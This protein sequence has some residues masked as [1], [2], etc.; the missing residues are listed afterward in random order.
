MNN[1]IRY[2]TNSSILFQRLLYS[3]EKVLNIPV[4]T[5]VGSFRRKIEESFRSHYP[6]FRRS[7]FR[8]LLEGTLGGD[9]PIPVL[10]VRPLS[11]KQLEYVFILA[12]FLE[13]LAWEDTQREI[14]KASPLLRK[15]IDE[16]KKTFGTDKIP[17]LSSMLLERRAREVSLPPPK[18][19]KT[20]IKR[21]KAVG[22]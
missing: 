8:S 22:V 9:V 5:L 21:K 11:L 18:K 6:T 17:G 7:T 14:D 10:S 2:E 19:L 1:T 4:G 12:D 16:L 15:E 13:T 3:F 20:V